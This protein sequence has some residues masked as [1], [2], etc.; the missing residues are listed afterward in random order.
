[1]RKSN[2]KRNKE[3]KKPA[4]KKDG[5]GEG[6]QSNAGPVVQMVNRDRRDDP[7]FDYVSPLSSG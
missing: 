7:V 3:G 1:M 4:A 5:Q 6:Q 2:G